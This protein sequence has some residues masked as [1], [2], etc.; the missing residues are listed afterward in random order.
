MVF[1][2]DSQTLGVE[3]FGDGFEGFGLRGHGKGLALQG[4]VVQTA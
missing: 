2:K 3:F 1:V 4:G